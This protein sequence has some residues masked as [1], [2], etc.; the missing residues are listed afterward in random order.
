ML[1]AMIPEYSNRYDLESGKR[2][3]LPERL[4]PLFWPYRFEDLDAAR[5]RKT[6]ILRL[7]N[8]GSLADW[9]WLVSHYGRRSIVQIITSV[10]EAEINPRSRALASLLFSISK[11]PSH[12]HRGAN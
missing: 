4:R 2:A 12:A 10:P 6:V 9:R 1:N 3:P 11:S 7:L 5:H 8:Y